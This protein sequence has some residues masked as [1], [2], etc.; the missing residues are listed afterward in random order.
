MYLGKKIAW[1]DQLD[2]LLQSQGLSLD[3]QQSCHTYVRRTSVLHDMYVTTMQVPYESPILSQLLDLICLAKINLFEPR[4]ESTTQMTWQYSILYQ[5]K[6]ERWNILKEICKFEGIS[7]FKI[8]T[9]EPGPVLGNLDLNKTLVGDLY[10]GTW[11][12]T[13]EPRPVLVYV[14]TCTRF[15]IHGPISVT[16]TVYLLSMY[17]N[18]PNKRACMFISGKVCLLGSIEVRGQTLPEINVH[19][20]LFGTL[21]YILSF[22]KFVQILF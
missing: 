3:S 18:M 4:L 19:A 10:S 1:L 14:L 21:E 20:R 11:T 5:S 17:S 7:L 16:H 15:C 9:W 6:N 12:C 2:H 13:R 8:C 22:H